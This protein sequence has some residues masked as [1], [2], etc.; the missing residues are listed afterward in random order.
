MLH[1]E[2]LVEKHVCMNDGVLLSEFTNNLL[3]RWQQTACTFDESAWVA[4]LVAQIRRG[5]AS[6][7]QPGALSSLGVR[8]VRV[9][10]EVKACAC[11]RARLC[12]CPA[13]GW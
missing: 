12:D 2:R 9:L 8:M 6:H 1:S 3:R 5:F 10:L 7:V 11:P 13:T 4:H